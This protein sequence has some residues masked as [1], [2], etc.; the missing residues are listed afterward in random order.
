MSV[1][2]VF[3]ERKQ[4]CRIEAE[5]VKRDLRENLMIANLENV[6]LINRYYVEGIS[7]EIFEKAKYTIFSEPQTD[8]ATE[9][10]EYSSN[11][12]LFAVEYLPG[13]FD[14][15]ADSCSQCIQ[16][17]TQGDRPIVK[18]AKFGKQYAEK[19]YRRVY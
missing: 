5:G 10:I 6:R 11:D 18:T 7:E 1:F 17:L 19:V 12:K 8:I 16:L 15:R 4:D 3:V 13:Q 2:K 14:Q 9:N